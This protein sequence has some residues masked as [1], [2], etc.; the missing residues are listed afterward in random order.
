M[1]VLTFAFVSGLQASALSALSEDK[2]ITE[3]DFEEE[4]YIDDIPFDTECVTKNCMYRKAISVVFDLDEEMYVED[5][6]FNTKKI[7][8]K[9]KY[10]SSL[11][12]EFEMED[13][14]YI[15]DIPFDTFVLAEK[16][17][18]AKMAFNH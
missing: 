14:N 2:I 8:T 18:C 9:T 13:E 5:I 6:P 16:I 11:N 15:D 4:T 12:S 10:L 7:I 3:F 17:D 1:I